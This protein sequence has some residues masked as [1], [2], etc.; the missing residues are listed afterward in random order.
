MGWKRDSVMPGGNRGISNYHI[1]RASLQPAAKDQNGDIYRI[2]GHYKVQSPCILEW[3][4]P[5]NL[6]F[7]HPGLRSPVPVK[8]LPNSDTKVGKVKTFS[9]V[10]D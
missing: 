7:R 1:Q 2:L 9:P 3:T 8:T 4:S 6:S 10:E 5:S